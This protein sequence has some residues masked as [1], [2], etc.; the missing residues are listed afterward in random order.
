MVGKLTTGTVARGGGS[1]QQADHG[2]PRERLD[3]CP[4]PMRPRREVVMVIVMVVM[5]WVVLI[6]VDVL[7]KLF[8]MAFV[9]PAALSFYD[10]HR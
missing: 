9:D 2:S 10:S 7:D 4:H 1:G 3:P 6:F 5:I 8:C